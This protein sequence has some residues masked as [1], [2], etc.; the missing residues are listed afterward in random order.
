MPCENKFKSYLNLD[1]IDFLPK[2]LIVGTFN[3]AWPVSNP[4]EWFYGRTAN[5]FFWDVLPRLYHETSLINEA[6]G[7]WK[8]FCHNK[9]IAIT[10]LIC[11]IEDA[12]PDNPD[13]AKKLGGYSDNAIIHNFEDFGYINIV[14]LLKQHST[15]ENV[16]LTRGISDLFWRH[17]WNPVMHYCNHNNIYERK[18]LTPSGNAFYQHGMHN[19]QNPENQIP[20]PEDYILMK[21]QQEWHC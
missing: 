4:A 14:Q 1:R 21:W 20:L 5:N 11:S 8:Q 6:P 9:K 16:Y 12:E 10:D 17:L 7:V 3:P 2:T 19:K 13:H 15:I 18:L